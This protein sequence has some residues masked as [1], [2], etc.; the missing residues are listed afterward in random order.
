MVREYLPARGIGHV[1][2][3]AHNSVESGCCYQLCRLRVCLLLHRLLQLSVTHL[4]WSDRDKCWQRHM[5][6]PAASCCLLATVLPVVTRLV[7]I[8]GM[9]MQLAR[10]V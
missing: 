2:L 5:Y 6:R 7:S 3:R 1:R 8:H 4:V 10:L 9:Q